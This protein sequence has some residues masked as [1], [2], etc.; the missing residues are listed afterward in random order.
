MVLSAI[1]I[2][3]T[4]RAHVATVPALCLAALRIDRVPGAAGRH[5]SVHDDAARFGRV[6]GEL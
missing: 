3:G 1:V 2:W 5:V 6:D 4:V